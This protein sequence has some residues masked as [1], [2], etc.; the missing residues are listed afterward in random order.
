MTVTLNF[1]SEKEAGFK[2]QA[3]ARGLSLEQWI[4]EVADQSIEPVS[5]AHSQK[6]DREE[7]QRQFRPWAVSHDPNTPG[8]LRRGYEPGRYLSL[9]RWITS[10]TPRDHA[11]T[12]SFP[13]TAHLHT[14]W[15]GR[16]RPQPAPRPAFRAWH[17]LD[18]LSEG[19]VQ[20][21]RRRPGALPH[22]LCRICNTRKSMWRWALIPA[23]P[24]AT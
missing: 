5:I 19:R 9:G 3:R 11:R 23:G 13:M 4:Q 1:P 16:P 2:A 17:W 18:P 22:E 21:D 14:V 15:G 10:L 20:G 8:S 12:P 24:R 6:T 7:W